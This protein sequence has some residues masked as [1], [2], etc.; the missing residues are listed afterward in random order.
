RTATELLVER[1]K[2]RDADAV[3]ELYAQNR[4][5]VTRYLSRLVGNRDDADDLA[6]ET[7]LR[8]FQAIEHF[9]PRGRPFS[10]WVYRIAHNVAMDHFRA[11]N[12][13][14]KLDQPLHRGETSSA[15]AEDEALEAIA[16]RKLLAQFDD[17][18]RA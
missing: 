12:R 16:H 17:L 3:G 5:A 9:R 14:Q 6:A 11:T 2:H 15:S 10:S 4:E 18:S 1:A 8:V 13:A 7:F